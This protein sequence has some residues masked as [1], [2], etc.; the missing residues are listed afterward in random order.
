MK[1][2][3]QTESLKAPLIKP[4]WLR[5]LIYC[6]LILAVVYLFS[7]YTVDILMLLGEQT[8][9]GDESILSFGALYALMGAAVF[10]ITWLLRK[11]VDRQTFES[12]GFSWNGYSNEAG[13]GFFAALAMLGIGSLILIA[14]GFS[15]FYLNTV[16]AELLFLEVAIMIVVAFVEE[17]L[18]RGYL[19]NN[20]LQ[21]MN[22]WIALAISAA[23]FAAFHCTNPDITVF[24]VV[25]ILLAGLLLGLNYIFTKNLWF[26]ICFHFA[27]NYFQGPVLGYD[28]SGLKMSSVLQQTIT[29]PDLWTGGLFGFEGSL[30]C[31]LIFILALFAFSF[32]FIKKYKS[33]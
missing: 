16:D 5:A 31:P 24:A 11:F 7:I 19:L 21:S 18:F 10:L 23:L 4:G 6:M 14:T 3:I 13:Q 9:N 29:G 30:L 1:K 8:E 27:W 32:M 2:Q 22:K 12:L 26:G 25:N 33:A 15:S 20:L 28:V 17:L